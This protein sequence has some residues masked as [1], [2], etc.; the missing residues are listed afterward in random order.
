MGSLASKLKTSASK[1]CGDPAVASP[2]PKEYLLQ[3]PSSC[4][5]GKV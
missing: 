3:F 4:L 1:F 5:E 2:Q